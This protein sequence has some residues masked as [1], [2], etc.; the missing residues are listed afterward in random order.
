[1]R[2]SIRTKLA[3]LVLAVLLPLL[4]AAAV[5]FWGDMSEGRRVGNQSQLDTANLIAGRLDEILTGQ[6]E[7]L[8]ALASLRSLDSVQD[9]DLET[10]AG[11]VR[12]RHPFMRRFVAVSPDGR[13]VAT[14]GYRDGD[15]KFLTPEAIATVLGRGEPVVTM[16]HTSGSDSRQVVAMV[17][18][19][20]DPQGKLVGAIGAEVDLET[21]SRYLNTLPLGR[22][23]TVAVVSTNGDVLAR[24][25]SPHE[26]F[27][28][29]LSGRPEA[30]ALLRR[31][32]GSA[33][34]AAE[35]GVAHL[36]G[37]ASMTR[38]PWVVVAAMPSGA[39]SAPAANR[40]T[41]DLLALG[42][43]TV[44][45]LLVAWLIGNRMLRSVSALMQ[46]ARDLETDQGSP[47]VV[48]TKDELAELA[49]QFN[50]AVGERR[51]THAVL[52]ERQRRLRALADVNVAL[53]QQLE[54]KPLLGQ[55]TQALAQLT[56]A[57]T[58]VFWEVDEARGLLVR[59]AWTSNPAVALDQMPMSVGI[60]AGG[61]G[62][63]ARSRRPLFIEDVTPDDRLR[64]REWAVAHGLIS[65]AGV[66]VVA[67]DDL[68]GVLTLS[69]RKK[70]LPAADD[71]ELLTSFASQAAVA[72]RNAR[73][74]AEATRRRREA[75]ELAQ[76]AR[77]LT[78]SL[79]IHEVAD[80]VVKSVLPIFGVDAA[81]LRLMRPDGR[82]EAIAWAGSALGF[83]QPGH[84]LEPGDGLV[85]RAVTEGQA[86]YTRDVLDDQKLTLTDDLRTRLVESG[87]RSLLAAPL[88]AK[89]ELI[90][91]LA[92]ASGNVHDF[93]EDDANLLQ[94]FADQA[95]LAMQNARLYGDATRRQRES[96]EI[97]RV[98]QTLTGSLDE[99]DIAQRIVASVLP[100][101]RALSLG[102]RLLQPDGSLRVLAQAQAVG[103]IGIPGHVVPAGYGISGRVVA[104]GRPVVSADVLTDPNILLTA[105]MRRHVEETKI[106]AY[107]SVPLRLRDQVIG[108]LAVGDITGRQFTEVEAALLQT[109]ADQAALAL[110]HTRLYAQTRQR[111]RHVESIREVVEQVLV[112][113]SL[114]ERLNLI[115][116]KAAEL[117][118]ADQA[119]VALKPEGHDDLVI[120]AGYRLV[121]GQLGHAVALGEGAM[122]L[123]AAKREGILVNDYSSWSG[124]V[125]RASKP[126]FIETI[127]ATISYPLLIRGELIGALVVAYVGG[128]DRR[129]V[130]EDLD[131]LATFAAP[132]AL[133][134]EHSRLF[135]ELAARVRQLQETQAQL[136][137]AGKLSAVGQLVSGVAHELNNPLSVV[138][139]YGQLLKGK[140]LPP[141]LRGPIDLIV[142]QGERMAKIVQG[143]LLFSRQRKPERAP[144][145]LPSVIEQTVAL[146]TTRLRL[147]GIRVI[148]EHAPDLPPAEGDVHQLQQ[149]FLNL[150]LNAEHA[151]LSAGRGDTIRIRTGTRA[152]GGRHWVVV[153]FEDN[154]PGIAAEVMPRIFEPFFTT[155]KVGEGTG[156]GL[157]VSYGI[158]QQ[159]GGRLTGESVPG[160][161]VF[162]VE[163]PTIVAA[164]PADGG[165]SPVTPGVYG[166]GRRA[167]VVDDEPGMVELVTA[168]LRDSGWQV[169]VAATGRS[170]L[171]RV[172]RMRFD[173]VLSDIRMPDGSGEDFYLAAV[174]DQP[175][176]ARRFVFMTGDTANPAPW[177][178]V[179][180]VQAPVL[181]KPFT[182]D[183]LF[184][185]LERVSVLTSRAPIE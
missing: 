145:N 80:R 69:L 4:A 67:G 132:A 131:R 168:L 161:T 34:W 27:T 16:P 74:F 19:V 66:P 40:L 114:E 177:Q 98:A 32:E 159:H 135:D 183:H 28:R 139:G 109:F 12:E 39:A 75:E 182:A 21:L 148:S 25:V 173:V 100:V 119:V 60:D 85:A 58:V 163:L 13:V 24:S 108:T 41:R 50:R 14:S 118:D 120:R 15:P 1:M 166:F 36:A 142:A 174:L 17:V 18:P 172:R 115:A 92:V 73:L 35:D 164:E 137:Q 157:S 152:E 138:I 72:V 81:G 55:I 184:A 155:K 97:A 59:R 68:L 43:A 93:A 8:L 181:E 124:R 71:R 64:G 180:E 129:F 140:V 153:E 62:L 23:Q 111:L 84:M 169:E 31:G 130:P 57:G 144:V 42:A 44:L 146:R 176:L 88:R 147:S 37:A 83:F 102:F 104:E 95:A 103:T 113:L 105:E 178:F 128:Q 179:E 158:V 70:D 26:F 167:L 107:L 10:L 171:E 54:L 136:V 48:S 53:S 110:D 63:V 125:H 106:G 29:S 134:I 78:E 86:V 122:G 101:L 185:A 112:P 116:R 117:F 94:A 20:Q 45:A 175:G 99:D 46:G 49:D 121:P 96:E 162:T 91:V 170:A 89:G 30:D 65:F 77:M 6:I 82:L 7:S 141:E 76:V 156:L 9:A 151:I 11:R 87:M 165:R 123:A 52:D 143:L 22:E 133:A 150:L 160:R 51:Q 79:D 126:E 5:R 154:G 47:I 61:V 38:A 90:G 56:G 3:L 149:V 127:R 2:L 33:E